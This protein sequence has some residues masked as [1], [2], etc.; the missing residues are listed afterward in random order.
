[1]EPAFYVLPD[2]REVPNYGPTQA[3]RYLRMN[4]STL[5]TWF[6]GRPYETTAGRSHFDPLIRPASEVPKLLSFN[7]LI[8]AHMLLALRRVHE[9][10]M[11]AVR[12]AL[13]VAAERL[14]VGR[15]LLL[16]SLGTAFGEIF[17]EQYGR[18]VHLRRT[19]QIALEDYFEAHLQRVTLDQLFTPTEFFPF[20]RA[21]TVFLGEDGDRPISINPRRGFGQPVIAGTGIQTTVIA[22][23]M[24][25]G[26]DEHFLAEDY[27]LTTAQI[28]AAIVFEEAA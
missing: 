4:V 14:G 13:D 15:P 18:V 24:N 22:E 21:S 2:P 19:Q 6:F 12:E 5:R 3:A 9:V 1:M 16:D 10:P 26:E 27:G 28:R 8:E 17:I 25:A 23:R 20:P 7:N 11:S